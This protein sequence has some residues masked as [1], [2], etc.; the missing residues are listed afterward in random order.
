MNRMAR[1]VLD[2]NRTYA[3]TRTA[4]QLCGSHPPA[5]PGSAPVTDKNHTKAKGK[6]PPKQTFPVTSIDG[7]I[8]YVKSNIPMKLLTNGSNI[9]PDDGWRK[10]TL[11]DNAEPSGY[12]RFSLNMFCVTDTDPASPPDTPPNP[13]VA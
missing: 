10:N 1:I 12:V 7:R 11:L 6:Y 2:P 9:N 13:P 5:P 3:G 4:V 8:L